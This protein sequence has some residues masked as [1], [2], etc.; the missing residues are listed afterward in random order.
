MKPLTTRELV[1]YTLLLTVLVEGV[2]VLLRFGAGLRAPEVTAST[3]GRLTCGIRL[4]H[5]Y[6]GIAVLLAAAVLARRRPAEARW[7]L[8]IGAALLLSDLVHHF[9]VLWPVTG[10][11]QFDLVYP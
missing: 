8:A 7:L 6:F 3:V 2:T 9:L 4:H 11:P 10:S 5:G 1:V